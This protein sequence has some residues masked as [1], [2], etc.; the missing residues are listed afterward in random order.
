MGTELMVVMRPGLSG[1]IVQ[2]LDQL[3]SE[4]PKPGSGRGVGQDP[5]V[6]HVKGSAKRVL[7]NRHDVP[8]EGVRKPHLVKRA[9]NDVKALI[10]VGVKAGY[11]VLHDSE[12]CSPRRSIV[13]DEAEPSHLPSRP[14]TSRL[15]AHDLESRTDCAQ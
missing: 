12:V 9:G 11:W 7:G 14:E 3:C 15:Y 4:S 6:C 13:I 2:P 1:E 10:A 8:A 5:M